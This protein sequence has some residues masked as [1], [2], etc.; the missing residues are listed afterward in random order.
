MGYAPLFGGHGMTWLVLLSAGALVALVA[1]SGQTRT[2][3]AAAVALAA[4]WGGGLVLSQLEWTQPTG[5]TLD[6]ALVQGAI[7]QDLKHDPEQLPLTLTLYAELTE[8]AVGADLVVW[9]EAAIPDFYENTRRYLAA[10]QRLVADGGG[11]LLTGIPRLTPRPGTGVQNAL[12]ALTPE[13]QWYV[14]RHL[15]PFGEYFPVPDFVRS[16][17][18]LMSLPHSDF[19]AGDAGQ[20]PLDVAGEKIGVSIC[21][22]DVFGSEQLHYLPEATLLVNVSNDAWFGDSIAPHQH[23]QISQLRAAEAGRWIVRVTNTGV[24]AVVDQRGRVAATIPLFE[25]AVLEHTV[26]SYAGAT[27]YARLGNYPVVIGALL[28]L[29]APVAVRLR[30]SRAHW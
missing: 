27:P 7:T 16:W 18:K 6:V 20:P 10:A 26:P 15:V 1:P 12:V 4:A 25:K 30:A 23:L 17:L 8:R 24:S 28:V 9:P 21:Y 29:L 14:K 11:T 3:A 19:D 22:E 2:R 5:R 13:P